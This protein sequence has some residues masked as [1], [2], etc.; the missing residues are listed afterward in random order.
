MAVI[1]SG[2]K[3]A[4]KTGWQSYVNGSAGYIL[5]EDDIEYIC[6][7]YESMLVAR[8]HRCEDIGTEYKELLKNQQDKLL[9]MEK[10][11][12]VLDHPKDI[13]KDDLAAI[14]RCFSSISEKDIVKVGRLRE[15]LKPFLGNKTRYG[16]MD[17]EEK[18]LE[19]LKNALNNVILPESE[20]ISVLMKYADKYN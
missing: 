20:D 1:F 5:N 12:V 18:K 11:K 14:G 7:K 16:S 15:S 13:L 2:F 6:R 3:S 19:E 4:Y 8:R 9:L 10:C 17:D